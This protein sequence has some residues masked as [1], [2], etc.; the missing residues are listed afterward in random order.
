VIITLTGA[1]ALASHLA[2]G[3]SPPV[4]LTVALA[5]ATGFGALLGTSLGRRLPQRALGQGFAIVVSAVALFLL[6]DVLALGGPPG[7]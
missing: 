6:L 1:A 4:A 7:G 2:S 5:G 3:A